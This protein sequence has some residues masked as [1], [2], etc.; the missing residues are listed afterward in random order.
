MEVPSYVDQHFHVF[1]VIY[2]NFS[3]PGR[4]RNQNRTNAILNNAEGYDQCGDDSQLDLPAVQHVVH[5]DATEETPDDSHPN[6]H[7]NKAPNTNIVDLQ[8]GIQ[9]MVSL[10]PDSN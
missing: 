4:G 10:F 6:S 2:T 9:S 7:R 3:H 5:A 1:L 8:K